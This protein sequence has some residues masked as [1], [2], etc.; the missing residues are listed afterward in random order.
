MKMGEELSVAYI[1]VA[2][3]TEESTVTCRQRRRKELARG[4]RFA[5]QCSRCVK[6]AEATS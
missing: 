3:R 6:E 2:Q 1:D 4:W 5:C